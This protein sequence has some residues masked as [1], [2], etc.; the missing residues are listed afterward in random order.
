VLELL[1]PAF[2]ERAGE[3]GL[4]SASLGYDADPPSRTALDER[5]PRDLERGTTGLGPHLDEIRIL[6]GDRDLRTYGSQGEQR[7]AVLSL[8]LAESEVLAEQV[9]V[10]PLLL[11]DDALSELDADRRRVLS[12]RLGARFGMARVVSTAISIYATLA[13]ALFAVTLAGA[14]GLPVLMVMLF[15][16][17][18][19]LGLVIPATMVLSLDEHGP[20]AGMASALGGTLQMVAGGGVIAIVS[21]FFDGTSL[22]MVTAIALCAIGAFV[23]TRLTLRREEL[24]AQPAE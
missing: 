20:I 2:A 9:G 23:L 5:L 11:L 22:P 16:T 14:D 24:A 12:A 1:A 15:F 17:F 4:A 13:V 18:A 3:L 21:F 10:P 19:G 7:M 6:A 8:L